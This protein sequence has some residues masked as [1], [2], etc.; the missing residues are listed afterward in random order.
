MQA[1]EATS[2][3]VGPGVSEATVDYLLA[4]CLKEIGQVDAAREAL[5]RAADAQG[6]LLSVGGPPI[7]P[8]A[9]RELTNL[10]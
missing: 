3:P 9:V 7:E 1:L 5:R 6:A 10:P 4:M 8:L 2:L